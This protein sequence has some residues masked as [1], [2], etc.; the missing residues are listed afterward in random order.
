MNTRLRVGMIGVGGFG[1]YRRERMRE[2]GL[3][4]VAAYCDRNPEILQA[5]CAEEQAVGVGTFDELLAQPDLVC[6]S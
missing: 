6:R 3:F 4:Q 5:A 2:T 1:K